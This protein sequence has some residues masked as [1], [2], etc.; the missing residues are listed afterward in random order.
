MDAVKKLN[1]SQ[2]LREYKTKGSSPLLV[3]IVDGDSYIV[4]T[5]IQK[6]PTVEVINEL[7]CAY[8]AQC[9]SLSVPDF[10][11]IQIGQDIYQKYLEEGGVL[12]KLYKLDSFGDRF[13][14]G[15]KE[16]NNAVEFD[17]YMGKL[18]GKRDFKRFSSPLDLIKI[19]VFDQWVG[20]IDR[21][22]ENPNILLGTQSG[23]FDFHPIDHA[24]TFTN[25][26]NYKLVTDAIMR[27]DDN[28][29][30]LKVP[31]VKSLTNFVSS[32]VL[33]DLKLE[34]LECIKKSLDEFDS[35]FS[36]VPLD[37]GLSKKE[38]VH[39][40]DFFANQVRNE[41]IARSYQYFLR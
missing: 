20:N 18:S 32:S 33:Q 10:A 11:L 6:Q 3:L 26:S 37:W 19:G 39:L 12:S 15:S 14:F 34:F 28:L 16:I 13:Y 5:T 2:I 21:R 41:R 4:K 27:F 38:K 29:S 7:I 22:P 17:Q 31:F 35:I 30:I 8:L 36:Q 1:A 40:K 23:L 25:Q 9:W 24:S